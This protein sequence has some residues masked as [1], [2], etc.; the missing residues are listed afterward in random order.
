MGAIAMND[1]ELETLYGPQAPYSEYKRG[2]R[3]T[4]IQAHTTFT[5]VIIWVGASADEVL[6]QQLPIHYVVAAD[7]I[8]DTPLIIW[9]SDILEPAN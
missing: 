6:G 2:D 4:F 9:P 5:G 1:K 3:I 8:E 7:Q